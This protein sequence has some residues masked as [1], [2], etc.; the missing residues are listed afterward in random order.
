MAYQVVIF[1]D[2][3]KFLEKHPELVD[4]F[5]E[6]VD[7]LAEDPYPG[8]GRCLDIVPMKGY[9]KDHFRLRISKY[10]LLYVVVASV[11]EIRFYE[12]DKRGD[13]Y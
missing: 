11:V 4:R 10:R 12:A 13:I 6:C 2:V 3:E 7:D 9:P 8:Q 1:K 5:D